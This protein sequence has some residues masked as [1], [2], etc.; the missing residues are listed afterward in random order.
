M[1]LPTLVS[2]Q[3]WYDRDISNQYI[4]PVWPINTHDFDVAPTFQNHVVSNS[5]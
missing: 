4:P 5:D 1:V 3:T 2:S